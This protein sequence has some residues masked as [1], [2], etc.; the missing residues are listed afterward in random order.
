MWP[1]KFVPDRHTAG[2][3]EPTPAF[4]RNMLKKTP[5]HQM[6][7]SKFDILTSL[8]DTQVTSS[9]VSGAS[10]PDGAQSAQS[11]QAVRDGQ[12][13]N[14]AALERILHDA[15]YM[16]VGTCHIHCSDSQLAARQT[17]APGSRQQYAGKHHVKQQLAEFHTES[18][19]VLQLGWEVGDEGNL[20]IAEP[21]CTP[22]VRE[23]ELTTFPDCC[24]NLKVAAIRKLLQSGT[25]C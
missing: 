10:E 5:W 24:C 16:Q 9:Q 2:G 6:S 13:A 23:Q 22:R 8:C 20:L 18:A 11:V 1:S 7:S 15:L 12:V 3:G 19:S 21:L 17:H 14:W 4:V 25:C